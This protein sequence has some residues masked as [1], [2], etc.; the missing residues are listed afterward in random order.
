[1]I[2]MNL[3]SNKGKVGCGME[4]I[5][6]DEERIELHFQGE[7][8]SFVSSKIVYVE[9]NEHK[10]TFHILDN[11]GE[12]H[13][14]Y[15]Y[16]Q[17]NHVQKELAHLDFIRIHQSY[18]VNKKYIVNVYRYKAELINGII[19]SISKKYYKEVRGYYI[20]RLGEL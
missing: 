17:L 2:F 13:E 7:S 20:Q 10:L 5:Q 9:S 15:V 6:C 4:K 14:Y 16:S 12:L 18:L 8:F 19:L 3:I 11:A 1:M